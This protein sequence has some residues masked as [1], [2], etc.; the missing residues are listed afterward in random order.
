MN[1]KFT[2]YLITRFNVPVKNWDK[3]KAGN[4]VLDQAWL[5]ERIGLFTKF[6]LP[7]IEN[8]LNQNFTWLIFCDINTPAEY[9]DNIQ[10]SV[11][12]I[13]GASLRLVSHFDHLMVDLRQLLAEDPSPFLITSRVDNDDGLGPQFIK[14]V[15]AH[16][17][18]EDK[19]IINFTKGVLYDTTKRIL[20][21]IQL[22]QFNHYG[23]LI[24]ENK[25]GYQL[26]T[27]M[28]FPHDRPRNGYKVLNIRSRY[29]WLKIIHDRNMSSKTN[30][31]PL[32]NKQIVSIF[33]LRPNDL[34]QSWYAT[35]IYAIS[36]VVS[37]V[38][39]KLFPNQK[40]DKGNA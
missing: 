33:N 15:Q 20:T 37:R 1:G 34:A 36:R 12:S 30:G 35:L 6:C 29:A 32:R 11:R 14:D 2:H 8:Q 26:M 18:T 17:A 23:S 7:T 10:Q 24:E 31:I 38:G 13:P 39:R 19:L 27:V 4:R 28:G 21:E 22:S 3:D 25:S 5:D 16:F 40:M 9:L